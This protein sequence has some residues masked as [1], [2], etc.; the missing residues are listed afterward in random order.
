MLKA[1]EILLHSMHQT[2]S[3][4]F[5]IRKSV[6]F[7]H[8]YIMMLSVTSSLFLFFLFLQFCTKAKSVIINN[9]VN[10][11]GFFV[12]HTRASCHCNE[13]TCCNFFRVQRFF[14]VRIFSPL[15]IFVHAI[16]NKTR[17]ILV[18]QNKARDKTFFT[19]SVKN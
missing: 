8:Y 5:K 6:T 10:N 4:K 19:W 16:Q 7:F 9:H 3:L 14:L 11:P 12:S 18:I 1:L 13:G 2:S 15:F 17:W